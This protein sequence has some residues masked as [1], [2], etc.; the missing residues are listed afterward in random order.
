MFD[1]NSNLTQY[2]R[3]YTGE[4]PFACQICDRKFVQKSHL[5]RHQATHIE[6]RSLNVLFARR[7]DFSK[8]KNDYINTCYIIMNL[9]L[10]VLI[11]IILQ[12]FVYIQQKLILCVLKLLIF[13]I[14]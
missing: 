14:L 10:L 3:I 4:K 1:R 5:V 11:V 7:V 9:N 13:I 2:Y 6:I 8:L 12:V